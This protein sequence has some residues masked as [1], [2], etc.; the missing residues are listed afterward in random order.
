MDSIILDFLGQYDLFDLCN[1][2]DKTKFKL[3]YRASRDG[4]NSNDFHRLCDGQT[5]TL[6]IIKSVD[7]FIFGGYTSQKWDK[8][9][10]FKN[11]IDEFLF[12]LTNPR[13]LPIKIDGVR[14]KYAIHCNSKLGPCF[15]DDDLYIKDDFGYSYLGNSFY[16]KPSLYGFKLTNE[17]DFAI[18]EIEVFKI[19]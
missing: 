8:K 10:G 11:Y 4:L 18:D 2:T 15:G 3:I 12:S 6:T 7:N 5:K 16:M 9:S 14:N 17:Y 19:E 1:Y 13:N